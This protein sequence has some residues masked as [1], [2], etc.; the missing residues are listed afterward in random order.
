MQHKNLQWPVLAVGGFLFSCVRC[1]VFKIKVFSA[2]D[3]NMG[4]QKLLITAGH[5]VVNILQE[6]IYD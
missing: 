4:P 6:K 5:F 3:S 1:S 2:V